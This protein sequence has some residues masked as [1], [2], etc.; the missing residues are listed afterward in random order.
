MLNLSTLPVL[1]LAVLTT[2]PS[3]FMCVSA[4]EHRAAEQYSK[5]G[6][7]KS[8]KHLSMSNLSLKTRQDLLKIRR[9]WEASLEIKRRC[10]SKVI[11]E[12]HVTPNISR[13]S[14]SCTVLPVVNGGYWGCILCGLETIIVLVLLTFNFI[15]QKSHRS[16]TLP[17]PRLRNS[18][19]ATLTPGNAQQL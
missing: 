2:R 5:T 1:K 13:S 11:L 8:R 18:A 14:E 16:L 4:A 7:T 6:R 15:L 3:S 12:S 10:F 17:R 9:I 19:T